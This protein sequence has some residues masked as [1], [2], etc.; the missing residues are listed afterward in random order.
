MYEVIVAGSIQELHIEA[1]KNLP[2]RL[3]G[4]AVS[5][6]KLGFDKCIVDDSA[7]LENFANAHAHWN[8]V[9]VILQVIH[10]ESSRAEFRKPFKTPPES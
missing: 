10:P 3:P 7:S 9:V 1:N 5:N 8:V 2:F 6:G 4:T